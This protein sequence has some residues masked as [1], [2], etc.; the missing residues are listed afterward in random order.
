MLKKKN[1]PR[2]ERENRKE[3]RL[4][5]GDTRKRETERNGVRE[6]GSHG[7]ITKL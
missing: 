6:K 7:G 4:Q 3:E 1:R 5:R 2:F